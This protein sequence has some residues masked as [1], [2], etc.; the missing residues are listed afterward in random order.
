MNCLRSF[1]SFWNRWN[2][3]MLRLFQGVFFVTWRWAERHR[4]RCAT[5]NDYKKSNRKFRLYFHLHP[6][7]MLWWCTQTHAREAVVLHLQAK[8]SSTEFHWIDDDPKWFNWQPTM[9]HSHHPT[10]VCGRLIHYS[11]WADNFI[12]LTI[13]I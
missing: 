8:D 4:L 9:L 13:F 6:P 10:G 11:D 3:Q 2:V 12:C 1:V 5:I 7:K